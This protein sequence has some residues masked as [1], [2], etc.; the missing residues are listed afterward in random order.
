MI[1]SEFA[2]GRAIVT[3]SELNLRSRDLLEQAL[4]G[5]WVEGEI[6]N[7]AAPASGHWYFTLKDESAQIRCAMFRNRN[8]KRR[9]KPENGQQ[10]LVRG[11]VSLYVARGDYQLIV[12]HL[13][14]AGDGRLQREF[15]RLKTRLSSAGLFRCHN[16]KGPTGR[17]TTYRCNYVAHRGGHS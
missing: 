8:V 16:Q 12:E 3:V 1:E 5:V 6:S 7:L 15:E 17:A 11:G 4:P 13:E 14:D 9:R 10:I 2:E